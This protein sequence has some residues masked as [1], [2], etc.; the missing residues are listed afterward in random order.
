MSAP[1]GAERVPATVAVCA[2]PVDLMASEHLS[3]F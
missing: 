2:P 1:L 3:D